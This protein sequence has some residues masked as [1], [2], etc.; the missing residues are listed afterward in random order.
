MYLYERLAHERGRDLA[1]QARAARLARSVRPDGRR[2]R[3]WRRR[4]LAVAV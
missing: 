2:W 1:R 4:R 3:V